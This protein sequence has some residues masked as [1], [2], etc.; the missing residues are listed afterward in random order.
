MSHSNRQAS[1]YLYLS[2]TLLHYMHPM[3]AVANIVAL[4]VLELIKLGVQG[5]SV[6]GIC[7][8]EDMWLAQSVAEFTRLTAK[9]AICSPFRNKR[10]VHR[11][12]P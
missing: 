10:V 9:L 11:C 7:G 8:S 4:R 3:P 1:R 5:R 12:V 2:L 6:S